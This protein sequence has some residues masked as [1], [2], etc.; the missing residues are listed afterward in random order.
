[1]S[2][3]IIEQNNK[4]CYTNKIDNKKFRRALERGNTTLINNILTYYNSKPNA[5]PKDRK[6][7]RF[8]IR[9]RLANKLFERDNN[10]KMKT[11]LCVE[12]DELVLK[13]DVEESHKMVNEL[14]DTYEK[15]KFNDIL[16]KFG[17]P[18]AIAELAFD[19][20]SYD[21]GGDLYN[22]GRDYKGEEEWKKFLSIAKP[23]LLEIYEKRPY[24]NYSYDGYYKF[25]A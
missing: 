8:K 4:A 19:L 17:F 24:Y 25:S 11:E 9:Q 5:I 21:T 10:M 20:R 7:E 12:N 15:S 6:H 22:I 16:L 3:K 18:H 1:M 2:L 13:I 23:E 14:L